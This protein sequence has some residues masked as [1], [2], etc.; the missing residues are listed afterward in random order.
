MSDFLR[1]G[2]KGE[3]LSLSIWHTVQHTIEMHSFGRYHVHLTVAK[4]DSSECY[5]ATE[6]YLATD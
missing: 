2:F 1:I 5:L 3:P 4:P 6:Y